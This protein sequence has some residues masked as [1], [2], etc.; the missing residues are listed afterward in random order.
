MHDTAVSGLA[1]L[2]SVNAAA[3][4]QELVWKLRL[5]VQTAVIQ[6]Q[7]AGVEDQIKNGVLRNPREVEVALL[8]FRKVSYAAVRRYRFVNIL[9]ASWAYHRANA[10]SR[11]GHWHL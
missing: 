4:T 6:N 5:Q 2:P 10:V 3:L 11:R 7:I 9:A 1:N 8:S